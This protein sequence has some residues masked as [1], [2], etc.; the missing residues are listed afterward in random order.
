MSTVPPPEHPDEQPG[1]QPSI[2][3]EQWESFQRAAAEDGGRN[4]PKEPSARARMVARRL[5]QQDAANAADGS[6]GG[7]RRRWGRKRAAKPQPSTPPGW[8]TG[9]A[10]Q[11]MNGTAGRRRRAKSAFG[12]LLALGVAVVAVRPSL[13]TDHIPGIGSTASDDSSASGDPFASG[14]AS[15]T[16]LPAETALP[17]AAPADTDGYSVPDRAHPFRDSP[18]IGWAEGA[19]AIVLPAAKAVPGMTKA[20]VA[21]ALRNTKA[22]LVD[23][24]LDP[25]VLRGGQP[26]KALALL[27]PKNPKQIARLRQDLR[28][29]TQDDDPLSV[30][31]RFDPEEA[32]P[33]GDVVK[34]RGHMTFSAARRGEVRV[35]ADYSFVYPLVKADAGGGAGD[36]VARTIIRRDLTVTVAHPGTWLATKGKLWME[37]RDSEFYNDA[38]G[39][40][41]GWFH[42][43]FPYDTPAGDQPSGPASDPYDR[44]KPL[45]GGSGGSG[46]GTGAGG[47]SGT[48]GGDTPAADD[49][50][51]TVSRT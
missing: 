31:T 1:E 47:T 42:P 43:T 12:V 51:G 15:P 36:T 44:T 35:H 16:P 25:A 24:N 13:V 8:R 29:P 9:P 40:H 19:D 2:S 4:A 14:D 10:W 6:R 23:A 3:D 30:F 46:A 11:E 20:E 5:R 39:I 26:D 49:Q 37:N 48:A 38:C 18:A 17:S 7:G 22:F 50:C 28:K 21:L 32:V 27:D 45:S 34:V 33:A 41:D